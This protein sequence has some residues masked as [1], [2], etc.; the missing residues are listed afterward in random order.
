MKDNETKAVEF[1]VSLRGRIILAQAMRIAISH[2]NL[3]P[4][5]RREV[6]NIQDMLFILNH[7]GL[8]ISD[9]PPVKIEV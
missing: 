5:D 4:E 7:W 8:D 9:D 2:L 6:S 3:Q 1:L